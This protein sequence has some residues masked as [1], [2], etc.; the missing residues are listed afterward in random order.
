MEFQV[1]KLCVQKRSLIYFFKKNNIIYDINFSLKIG[2]NLVVSCE[3]ENLKTEILNIFSYS[4]SFLEN[5]YLNGQD[6]KTKFY[7]S[8]VKYVSK[9]FSNLLNPHLSLK[10]QLVNCI[11]S[12]NNQKKKISKILQEVGLFQEHKNYY[13]H[14]LNSDEKFRATLAK[15][16]INQP[17]IVLF[18]NFLQGLDTILVAKLLNLLLKIQKKIKVSYI[19]ALNDLNLIKLI[20]DY[21]LVLDDGKQIEFASK[22]ELFQNPNDY[23]ARFFCLT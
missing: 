2:K 21:I 3:N 17:K 1:R 22:D 7:K 14:E 18:D 13:P 16:F 10:K 6:Q 23:I 9:D 15:V 4:T 8:N 20:G 19:F 5:I 12:E 11:L